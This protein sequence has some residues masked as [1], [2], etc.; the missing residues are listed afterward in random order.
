MTMVILLVHIGIHMIIE[1]LIFHRKQDIT[2]C[3]LVLSRTKEKRALSGT[4]ENL[5]T[6]LAHGVTSK[7]QYDKSLRDSTINI[8][9][10]GLAN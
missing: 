6:S 7:A 3:I 1:I 8:G 4:E 5:E 10:A 9:R 2:I